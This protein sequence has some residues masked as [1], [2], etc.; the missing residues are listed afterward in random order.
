MLSP[1]RSM[2]LASFFDANDCSLFSRL[3]ETWRL[4][5]EQATMPEA[6]DASRVINIS[7][8]LSSTKSISTGL[9]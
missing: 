5:C 8:G 9:I 4:I 1:L 3:F 6:I 7:A 2:G